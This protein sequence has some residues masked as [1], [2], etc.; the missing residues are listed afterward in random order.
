M[1]ISKNIKDGLQYV[2]EPL[3]NLELYREGNN[4][5]LKATYEI[6]RDAGIYEAIIPKIDLNIDASF[7][8]RV[9]IDYVRDDHS[10]I[11]G[12]NPLATVQLS[13]Y[14]PVTNLC[15]GKTDHLVG[16]CYY[17]EKLIKSKVKEMTIEEIE[18]KLGH[19]VKIVK[20]K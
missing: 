7:V 14:G 18:K 1:A 9:N 4:Y 15:K 5:Y 13:K 2:E 12:C 6:E 3:K 16:E 8:P 17:T 19:P 11:L 10:G 20:S